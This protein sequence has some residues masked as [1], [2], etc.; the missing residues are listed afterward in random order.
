MRFSC[1]Y[2]KLL[3]HLQNVANVVED[4]LSSEDDKNIIF[5]FKQTE[6]GQVVK[7][8]GISL[9]VI[10]REELPAEDYDL[11]LGADEVDQN[12]FAYMQLKSKDLLAFLNSYKSVRRTK[13][14]DVILEPANGKIKCTV[15]ESPIVSDEELSLDP[16]AGDR[17]MFSQW[18][19]SNIPIKPNKLPLLTSQHQLK[20]LQISVQQHSGYMHLVYFLLWK[21][22]RGYMDI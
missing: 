5:Q 22:F 11:T 4:S 10:F 12:G 2:N 3:G 17:T 9:Q 14:N 16:L 6:E 21:I 8:V 7:L 19:F 1:N 20:V 18:M 13:V 15:T